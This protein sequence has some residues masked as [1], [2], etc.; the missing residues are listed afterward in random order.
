VT[1]KFGGVFVRFLEPLQLRDLRK[2]VA[3]RIRSSSFVVFKTLHLKTWLKIS[4]SR[5]VNPYSWSW[6]GKA[7]K[8]GKE[9]VELIS[10]YVVDSE[11]LRPEDL[12]VKS[13]GIK[14]AIS[15]II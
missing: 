7:K 8:Y 10:H 12:I 14:S 9:F 11:I 13:T 6:E 1:R 3:K 15:H 2:K 4:I 5:R